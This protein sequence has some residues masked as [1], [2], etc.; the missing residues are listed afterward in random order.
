MGS[1]MCIRDRVIAPVFDVCGAI[2]S[3]LAVVPCAVSASASSLASRSRWRWQ[4][5]PVLSGFHSLFCFFPR[6]L[7]CVC[8]K[9][10]LLLAAVRGPLLFA[11]GLGVLLLGLFQGCLEDGVL[12]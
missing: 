3:S 9:L 4:W 2:I 5:H 12:G 1:E 11:L 10:G 6:L 7:V 8:E